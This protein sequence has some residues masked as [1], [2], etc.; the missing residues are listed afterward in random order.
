MGSHIHLHNCNRN[1]RFMCL[2]IAKI[3]WMIPRVGKSGSEVPMETQMLLLEAEEESAIDLGDEDSPTSD[4]KFYVLML[5]VLDG[6]FRTTLQGNKSN[7][8]H[9]CYESGK[10]HLRQP[11]IGSAFL[12]H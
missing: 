6:A 2:F 4:N 5:P 1:Y 3:W 12:V 7:E 10:F 11:W 8:L 9:F